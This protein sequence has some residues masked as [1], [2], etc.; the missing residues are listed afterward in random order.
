MSKKRALAGGLLKI[1]GPVPCE[2]LAALRSPARSLSRESKKREHDGD[3][4]VNFLSSFFA[5]RTDPLSAHSQHRLSLFCC[6]P[7][8]DS[9][10]DL[11]LSVT[12]LFLENNVK[13]RVLLA[14]AVEDDYNRKLDVQAL[15]THA[16]ET[17]S[18]PPASRRER[19]RRG[20]YDVTNRKGF[21]AWNCHR[22]N[23]QFAY[24]SNP[25]V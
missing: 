11:W 5:S 2:G 9:R 25:A 22:E 4:R 13:R 1:L 18:F 8:A 3:G 14:L 17:S 16:I 6:R 19:G 23:C 21:C 12:R 24:V 10:T 20:P 7:R 15:S